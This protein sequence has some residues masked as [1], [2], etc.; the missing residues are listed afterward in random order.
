M[1]SIYWW[2]WRNKKAY[3]GKGTL[4][5][6]PFI[7]APLISDL[8]AVGNISG[9]LDMDDEQ[10][11]K[12]ITGWEDYALASGDQKAYEIL[13]ILN[14]SSSRMFYKTLPTLIEDGP[15][16]ALQYEAGLYSTDFSKE[17]KKKTFE[18]DML[19]D[20]TVPKEVLSALDALGGHID[21]AT[22]KRY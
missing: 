14:V 7:G 13:K 3:Y 20:P 10:K 4:T 11:A 1:D 15:G 2:G 22:K 12:L 5:Q 16:A 8:I 9:L 21:D 18:G 17:L 19:T 6:L